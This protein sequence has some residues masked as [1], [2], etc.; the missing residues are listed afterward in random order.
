M[1]FNPHYMLHPGCT[2]TTSIDTQKPSWLSPF[3]LSSPCEGWKPGT[4]CKMWRPLKCFQGRPWRSERSAEVRITEHRITHHWFF[5]TPPPGSALPLEHGPRCSSCPSRNSAGS[6]GRSVGPPS[7]S[8]RCWKWFLPGGETE[9]RR[10][11]LEEEEWADTWQPQRWTKLCWGGS[12][13]SSFPFSHPHYQGWTHAHAHLPYPL[14]TLWDIG[15]LPLPENSSPWSIRASF[16]A[17]YPCNTTVGLKPKYT[18]N[19]GP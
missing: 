14:L 1:T 12:S 18:V 8:S 17:S 11:A 13:N 15:R 4:I 19:T 2:H 7:I 9:T 3:S 6:W 16:T 5:S 10:E